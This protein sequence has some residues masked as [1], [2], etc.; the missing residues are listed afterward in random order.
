MIMLAVPTIRRFSLA[1]D[2]V[3]SALAGTVRPDRVLVIDQSGGACPPIPGAEMRLG[4]QPQALTKAW[5][6]AAAWADGDWLIITNDDVLFA[7]DT[8]ERMVRA[9][10]E[11][12]RAGTVTCMPGQHFS[13]FLLRR[14]AYEA[15]GPFDEQFSPAYFEDN[16]YTW[17][18]RLAG[19]ELV[20]AP[21]AVQHGKS[22]SLPRESDALMQRHHQE[23]R[24]NFER[25]TAKWGG[26]PGLERFTAPYGGE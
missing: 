7:P 24:A 9:A 4:R 16:D 17:R 12:P 14:A 21:T 25:Y 11:A 26:P 3:W 22:A 23:F 5:N 13:C 19:W 2:C 18:M 20:D 15:V 1:A 10:E 8:I 6:D